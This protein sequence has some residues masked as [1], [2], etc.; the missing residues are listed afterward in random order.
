M[1]KINVSAVML[2]CFFGV[3][4]AMDNSHEPMHI[5]PMEIEN[6]DENN[7]VDA[8]ANC[9]NSLNTVCPPPTPRKP[10]RRHAGRQALVAADVRKSLVQV[11]KQQAKS[12]KKAEER[13]KSAKKLVRE[14][15][16]E[17][18]LNMPDNTHLLQLPTF[19]NEPPTGVQKPI[20][21]QFPQLQ[22]LQNSSGDQQ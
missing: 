11:F 5:E 6:S 4:H 17:Q 12:D 21:L 8:L 13:K 19:T 7:D 22:N 9:F 1:C 16:L 3:S 20:V 2:F 10:S 18:I 14:L 15:N